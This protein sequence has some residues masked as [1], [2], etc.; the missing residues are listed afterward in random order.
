[1]PDTIPTG[2]SVKNTAIVSTSLSG[3][4]VF[5]TWLV[6]LGSSTHWPP[7]QDVI[8]LCVGFLSPLFH[9][10]G[11]AIYRKV[12]NWAGE[13]ADLLQRPNPAPDPNPPHETPTV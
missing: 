5:A 1:M 13:P 9:L 3:G 8:V 7:P 12:A 10:I 2:G 11:R 4:V 6:G